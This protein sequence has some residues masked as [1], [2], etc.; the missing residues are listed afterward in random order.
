MIAGIPDKKRG[1]ERLTGASALLISFLIVASIF[2]SLDIYPEYINIHEDLA[3]LGENIE[4]LRLNTWIWFANSIMIILFGP[5]ILM[6]FLPH[7]RS[8]SYL[9]AFL[10]STTGI[11][12]MIFTVNGYN[13]I[14]LVTDYIK[15]AE[16]EVDIIASLAYN[17][18]VTKTN[19]QLAAYTLAGLSSMIL[20]LLIAS[21]SHIPRFIGWLA[22]FGGMIY[23]SFGWISTD[24]IL[25]TIGRLFFILALIILGSYLLLK[26]IVRKEKKA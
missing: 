5:L 13:M 21:T 7:G 6:S 19:L 18:M 1:V 20:G 8:S 16:D 4:R 15:S 3:Y 23:A 11:L 25:F 17:I 14:F 10:I 22:I 9:A 24:N 12:Y 2:T 26:G